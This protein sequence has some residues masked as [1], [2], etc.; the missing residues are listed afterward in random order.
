M[1]RPSDTDRAVF[2]AYHLRQVR[3]GLVATA[4]VLPTLAAVPL[5]PNTGRA[6]WIAP[7]L[8]TLAVAAIGAGIVGVFPWRRLLDSG[9]GSPALYGWSVADIV[10]ISLLV[11]FSGG[12]RSDLFAVYGLTIAFAASYRV[13]AQIALVAFTAACYALAIGI[14]QPGTIEVF[15][16]HAAVG[17]ALAISVGLLA[18]E[19]KS[20]TI[21]S[22]VARERAERSAGLLAAVAQGTTRL[23]LD[24]DEAAEGALG[25]LEA[26]GF[27]A[28][29]IYVLDEEAPIYRVCWSR[30]LV[31]AHTTTAHPIS[32][33]LPGRV[34]S[35]GK[36]QRAHGADHEA[37]SPLAG[38]DIRS[39]VAC[40]VWI[41]GWLAA[42]LLA[43]R[44]TQE[45]IDD[46]TAQVA[47]LIATH[48]GLEL[49]N[50]GRHQQQRELVRHLEEIDRLKSDFLATASHELRT[51][52]TVIEGI[53]ATLDRSWEELDDASR[54][55]LLESLRRKTAALGRE[56]GSML[57]FSQL[58]SDPNG[59]ERSRCD[60]TQLLG[61]IPERLRERM[62][63][64]PLRLG[65]ESDLMVQAD[66]SLIARVVENLLTNAAT[67]TPAGTPVELSATRDGDVIL[68]AV[69]HGPGISSED[70]A[71]MGERFFRGGELNARPQ[72]GLGL[73]LA[74][75][76]EI[77]ELHGSALEV[78]G[79]PGEGARFSFHLPVAEPDPSAP[80]GAEVC[81]V[82]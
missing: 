41:D 49:S 63:D 30:R 73:G 56:L 8:V 13:G 69:D 31:E 70:L 38:A 79:P 34:L 28:S 47:E 11:E 44:N 9:R 74:L 59:L 6:I 55:G 32:A 14:P 5:L 29:G 62:V 65:V 22:D 58:M 66:G 19:M 53:G 25:A 36:V 45:E 20:A 78:T 21:T 80:D 51:P 40:P 23:A 12:A 3:A 60:L 7:Y 37:L 42:V 54:R 68:V 17:S 1:G 16:L 81:E 43:G 48:A 67:H 72:G 52:L 77:L 39:A 46:E 64:H 50:V 26:L 76:Q 24:A 10:L 15:A 75:A 35:T 57:E 71:M 18:S 2:A 33:G 4:V 61:W 27:H 82:A